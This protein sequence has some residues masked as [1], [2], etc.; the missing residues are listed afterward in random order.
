M[1]FLF[2]TFLTPGIKRKFRNQPAHLHPIWKKDDGVG[3]GAGGACPIYAKKKNK[4]KNGRGNVLPVQKAKRREEKC[5][6]FAI[7]QGGNVL[8]WIK[9]GRDGMGIVLST[10]F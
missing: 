2:L 9:I 7:W 1:C 10:R 5:P 8:A 4:K 6:P 3:G